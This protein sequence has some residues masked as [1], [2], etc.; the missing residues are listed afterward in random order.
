MSKLLERLVVA[1]GVVLVATMLFHLVTSQTRA[2]EPGERVMLSGFC[3][4]EDQRSLE[5]LY[6]SQENE[7]QVAFTELMVDPDSLCG[8][9]LINGMPLV[10]AEFR[11]DIMSIETVKG[12]CIRFSLF[13]LSTTGE[14]VVSWTPCPEVGEP[15]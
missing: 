15:I 7:D 14:L 6:N 8:H 13:S 9:V 12:R 5:R 10:S 4:A 1:L 2:E 3:A 11:E